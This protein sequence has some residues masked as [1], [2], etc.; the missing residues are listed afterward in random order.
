MAASL[1]GHILNGRNIIL[2]VNGPSFVPAHFLQELRTGR[3]SWWMHGTAQ[4]GQL[5]V[6]GPYKIALAR[7]A[8]H[9][10]HV[11]RMGVVIPASRG[12]A[13]WHSYARLPLVT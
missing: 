11:V 9:L 13:K 4:W 10:F 8:E 7:M 5:L 12:G 2:L 6:M 1:G 3:N